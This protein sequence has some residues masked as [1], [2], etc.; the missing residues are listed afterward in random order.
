[1]Y[2]NLPLLA[3]IVLKE[4]ILVMLD[5]FKMIKIITDI[6][7]KDRITKQSFNHLFIVHSMNK[8]NY[9]C[10][11]YDIFVLCGEIIDFPRPYCKRGLK[12]T[13]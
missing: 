13:E 8:F 12:K 4:C 1:M 6:N 9:V 7:A 11:F 5:A 10:N 2:A 3:I